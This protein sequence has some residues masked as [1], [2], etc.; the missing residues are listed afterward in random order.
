MNML[1]IKTHTNEVW[2]VTVCELAGNWTWSYNQ[3]EPGQHSQYRDKAA[4]WTI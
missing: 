4:S 3:Q 2:Y 1:Q